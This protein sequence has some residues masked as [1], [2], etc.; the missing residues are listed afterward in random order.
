[1]VALLLGQM[2]L[3]RVMEAWGNSKLNQ[4]PDVP[5]A[6]QRG[7]YEHYSYILNKHDFVEVYSRGEVVEQ[8]G[9]IGEDAWLAGHKA[10]EFDMKRGRVGV[11]RCSTSQYAIITYFCGQRMADTDGELFPWSVKAWRGLVDRLSHT[12]SESNG[13][14][15]QPVFR[16]HVTQPSDESLGHTFAVHFL[17]DGRV[18][19]Y[20]SF[21]GHYS[22]QDYL[23][24]HGPMDQ[25]QFRRFLDNLQGL[26]EAQDWTSAVNQLYRDNFLVDLA[27][28]S[29]KITMGS[30]R[31]RRTHREHLLA[32]SGIS[33]SERQRIYVTAELVCYASQN[34]SR[35][36]TKVQL[37]RDWA[38]MAAASEL[39][40]DS[41]QLGGQE[42]S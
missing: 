2:V 13:T 31:R 23:Q 18:Q 21:I 36:A 33:S 39:G 15:R 30:G 5:D 29:F 3:H 20:Q 12:A 4:N 32:A 10:E 42:G 24:D 14:W 22:L 1:V 41:L 35:L 37:L 6:Q 38:L 26:E 19:V 40:T 27:M 11:T 17:P 16:V 8:T 7:P 34:T 28:S 9:A 25:Q